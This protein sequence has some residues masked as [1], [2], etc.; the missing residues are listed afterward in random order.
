MRNAHALRDFQ[1]EVSFIEFA[2]DEELALRWFQGASKVRSVGL[3]NEWGSR[4]NGSFLVEDVQIYAVDCSFGCRPLGVHS[5]VSRIFGF[6]GF[7]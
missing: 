2:D 1:L 6:I 3:E 4:M 5:A 7:F